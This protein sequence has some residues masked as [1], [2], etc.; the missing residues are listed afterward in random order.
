MLNFL[1]IRVKFKISHE[2]IAFELYENN[3]L[4]NGYGIITV[5]AKKLKNVN[6]FERAFPSEEHRIAFIVNLI[7]PQYNSDNPQNMKS[8][9]FDEKTSSN[10][11]ISY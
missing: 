4:R 1:K 9:K 6:K 2:L 5:N 10:S 3:I 8:S 11:K 7:I